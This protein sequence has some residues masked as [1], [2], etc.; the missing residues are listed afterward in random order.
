MLC[1]HGW[2]SAAVCAGWCSVFCVSGGWCH[3]GAV[4]V[5]SWCV[6]PA[7]GLRL[8]AQA[9]A[10]LRQR[11]MHV[12]V[13]GKRR[14]ASVLLLNSGLG[15]FFL[16]DQKFIVALN[17][18][19]H[20]AFLNMCKYSRF[21]VVLLYIEQPLPWM[22]WV[23]TKAF[24]KNS[25]ESSLRIVLR[26]TLLRVLISSFSKKQIFSYVIFQTI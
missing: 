6:H 25:K 26:C 21:A 17:R 7:P 18:T 24:I 19:A 15:L 22:V 1:Q 10:A 3:A 12:C 20:K 4:P 11:E 16:P 9:A 5:G 14:C 8:P 23:A 2:V 13:R